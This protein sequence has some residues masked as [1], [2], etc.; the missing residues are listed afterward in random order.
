MINDLIGINFSNNKVEDKQKIFFV[1][2]ILSSKYRKRRENKFPI[3]DATKH[4]YNYFVNTVVFYKRK[5]DKL[6]FFGMNIWSIISPQPD[7]HSTTRLHKRLYFL[8]YI[9]RPFRLLLSPI[10]PKNKI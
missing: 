4:H 2:T 5:K 8:Y 1:K 9:I 6:K 3:W 7:D 10:D